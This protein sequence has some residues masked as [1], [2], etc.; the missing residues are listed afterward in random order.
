MCIN[1]IMSIMALN[2]SLWVVIVGV[3]DDVVCDRREPV[4]G[5]RH[6]LCEPRVE[7][8]QL[9]RRSC[10]NDSECR[11]FGRIGWYSSD[12]PGTPKNTLPYCEKII[13]YKVSVVIVLR[14]TCM[15]D[16]LDFCH[17]WFSI[18][19]PQCTY[20]DRHVAFLHSQLMLKDP[21]ESV[22]GI[23]C[24]GVW[25]HKGTG[26]FS[27]KASIYFRVRLMQTCQL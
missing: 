17:S 19:E 14:N 13:S 22:Q 16:S 9:S 4:F 25:C 8:L 23:F 20:W 24:W 6:Y 27:C 10:L 2:S 18:N 26:H 12:I 3:L 1:S 7:E 15:L 11:I 21:E 5:E